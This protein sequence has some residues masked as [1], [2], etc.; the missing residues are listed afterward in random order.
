MIRRTGAQLYGDPA[1]AAEEGTRVLGA[2]ESFI[3]RYVVLPEA[4][5]LPV[6]LWAVATYMAD[7][8][9]VFPYLSLSS[10]LPRCGKT[11]A[12]EVLEQI[13][14]KPW[15]GTNITG[16][17]MFRFIQKEKPTLLLDE[18]E[19]LSGKNPSDRS[20]E[21]LSI[22]NAGYKKGQTVPRCVGPDNKIEQFNVYGPKAFAA[23]GSLPAALRDRC[24]IVPMHR[25][26]PGERVERF[27]LARARREAAPIK[28]DIERIVK[29]FTGNIEALYSSPLEIP[30]LSDRD[31]EV[32][33]PLFSIFSVL[34]PDRVEEL[35]ECA[36]ALCAAKAGD[37]VDDSLPLRLLADIRTVWR[38]GANA[39]LT[40]ELIQA[41]RALPESPWAETGLTPYKLAGRL[42]DF[43]VRPRTVRTLEGRGKGYVREEMTRAFER[44]L[45]A[46]QPES[47]S[48]A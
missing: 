23:I 6:T 22:L 11:R 47:D 35:N 34:A 36:R 32:F 45:P 12:L 15:H 37:A 3:T 26:A 14:A 27:R 8:F 38:E 24:I 33:A 39:M 25:R 21:V 5:R 40:E 41:L 30:F 43:G 19:L 29:D 44:Y 2:V 16:A 46:E 7:C 42:R 4:A 13:V 20:R 17:A 48:Q 31:E 9:D 28:A 18:V 1:L 10:P